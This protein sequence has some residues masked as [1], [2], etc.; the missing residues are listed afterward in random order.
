MSVSNSATTT[1]YF[2]LFGNF[3]PM[4]PVPPSFGVCGAQVQSQDPQ[5]GGND[6]TALNAIKFLI[7]SVCA[8]GCETCTGLLATDCLT[9]Q[10]GLAL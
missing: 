6:D 2:G 9:C 8:D 4:V 10:S 1:V 5:G 3:L 7:C